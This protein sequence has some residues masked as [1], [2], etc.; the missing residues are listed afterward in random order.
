MKI[1]E[2]KGPDGRKRRVAL[3]GK[4][5]VAAGVLALCLTGCGQTSVAEQT[6]EET[7]IAMEQTEE[8]VATSATS[9]WEE[10]TEEGAKKSAFETLPQSQIDESSDFGVDQ[11]VNMDTIDGYLNLSDAVYRDMRMLVDPYDYAA[12]GGDSILSGMIEGFTVIPYP[13]LAPAL[14][15]P[16]ALGQGYAG[17]TLFAM[18]EDGNYVACYEES[19]AILESIFPKDQAILLMCG[20]GGYASM[21]KAL[22]ISLGWNESLIYNVGG[23]WSYQGDYRVDVTSSDYVGLYEFNEVPMFEIDFA[24]LTPVEE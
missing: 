8:M 2:T 5:V 14:N 10:T 23:Y 3:P 4:W 6:K 13:Y 15:M 1:A 19:E 18:D 24:R 17:P 7:T 11:N 16:E 22:L 9:L 12:I 21:T 20:A